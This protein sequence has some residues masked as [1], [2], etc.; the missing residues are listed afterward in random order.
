MGGRTAR[1]LRRYVGAAPT[2]RFIFR[3]LIARYT[4]DL[5]M[6]SLRAT[7]V[8]FTPAARRGEQTHSSVK[9]GTLCSPEN[10]SAAL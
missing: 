6:P 7:S 5:P 10:V 1:C 2:T 4:L 8:G 9:I 3:S